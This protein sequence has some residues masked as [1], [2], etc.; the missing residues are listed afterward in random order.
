MDQNT[1]A[2]FI[3]S[4]IARGSLKFHLME[5]IAKTLLSLFSLENALPQMLQ[6]VILA[7]FFDY[8]GTNKRYFQKVISLFSSEIHLRLL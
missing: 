7:L 5:N 3:T 6:L 1:L 8:D 4:R 2:F